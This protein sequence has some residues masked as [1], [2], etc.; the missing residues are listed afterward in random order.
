MHS[1]SC[2][3]RIIMLKRDVLNH[4]ETSSTKQHTR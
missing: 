1:M 4:T 2:R 3:S